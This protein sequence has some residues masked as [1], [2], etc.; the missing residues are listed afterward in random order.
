MRFASP[1]FVLIFTVFLDLLGFGIVIPIL[2]VF[3]E[4]LGAT[5][6]QV[7]MIAGVF[8]IMNF[9]FAPWWGAESDRI[10]RRPVMLISIAITAAAYLLLGFSGSLLLLFVSRTLSGIG[11]AN[12][13]VAQAYITDISK[14]EDRTRNLG[15]IG[16][17]FGLGWVIGPPLGGFL[18][19]HFGI[20]YVGLVASSLGFINLLLAWFTLKEPEKHAHHELEEPT[21]ANPFKAVAYVLRQ[22]IISHLVWI[23]FIFIAGFAMMQVTSTLLWKNQFGLDDDHIGYTFGFLGLATAVV[24]GGLVRRMTITFGEKRLLLIGS[25]IMM[26]ALVL[27][28][29]APREMFYLELVSLT[30]I[31]LANGALTPSLSSLLAGLSPKPLIGR[32]LGAAQSFAS[33]ARAFGPALGGFLY[34]LDYHLPFFAGAATMVLCAGVVVW[35]LARLKEGKK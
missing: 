2:P 24:Q 10:G 23:N 7:G 9:L 6:F 21:S 26:A 32:N 27:M 1:L 16:A 31:A 17:A 22:P 20:F 5:S 19:S 25:L 11:S 33:L 3:A 13:A 28:P 30:G 12:I 8:A 35:L 15:L 4:E 34:G 14:P 18:K 29:L